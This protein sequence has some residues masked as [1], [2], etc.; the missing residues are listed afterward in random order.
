MSKYSNSTDNLAQHTEGFEC[1]IS[2]YEDALYE[3]SDAEVNAPAPSE[4][5]HVRWRDTEE[6]DE[7]EGEEEQKIF[8]QLE[9]DTDN[10]HV[11]NDEIVDQELFTKDNKKK[12]KKMSWF[13][14]FKRF[15]SNYWFYILLMLVASVVIYCVYTGRICNPFSRDTTFSLADSSSFKASTSSLGARYVSMR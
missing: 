14:M 8:H 6:R 1:G 11:I 5:I 15:V 9:T 3:L 2:N 10:G 4:E 12:S 7:M 13:S